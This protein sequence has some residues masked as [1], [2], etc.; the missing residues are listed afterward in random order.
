MRINLPQVLYCFINCKRLNGQ[1]PITLEYKAKTT[2][3]TLS[4]RIKIHMK[5]HRNSTLLTMWYTLFL[6]CTPELKKLSKITSSYCQL[7]N[8]SISSKLQRLY[9]SHR[10]QLESNQAPNPRNYGEFCRAPMYKRIAKPSFH[11]SLSLEHPPSVLFQTVIRS[12]VETEQLAC[13]FRQCSASTL[14]QPS[15]SKM[16]TCWENLRGAYNFL[17]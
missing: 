2:Y 8:P 17:Y 12:M 7:L 4:I 15:S 9:P 14:A 6:L 1:E 5:I 11:S 16:N 13:S 3:T 10:Y